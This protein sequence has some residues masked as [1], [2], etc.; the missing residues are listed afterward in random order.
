M[1]SLNLSCLRK[2][3]FVRIQ[4]EKKVKFRENFLLMIQNIT[5]ILETLF[6]LSLSIKQKCG[7]HTSGSIQVFMMWRKLQT[8]RRKEHTCSRKSVE[9]ASKPWFESQAAI[10]CSN[11]GYGFEYWHSISV[12]ILVMM[13]KFISVFGVSKQEPIT[14]VSIYDSLNN[15]SCL[16]ETN[17]PCLL[18]TAFLVQFLS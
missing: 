9:L 4:R 1:I 7:R 8:L 3:R 12:Q 6:K 14:F 17:I 13:L 2:E 5:V 18:K 10:L 15:I 16:K 11:Y